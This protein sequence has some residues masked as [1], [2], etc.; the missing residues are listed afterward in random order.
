MEL[1]Q[2]ELDKVLA[3]N[4]QGMSEEEALKNSN[5]YRNKKLEELKQEKKRLEDFAKNYPTY[6]EKPK[7]K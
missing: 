5:L 2:E 1:K 7:S 6:N 4:T 3:G